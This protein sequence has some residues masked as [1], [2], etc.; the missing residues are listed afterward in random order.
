MRYLHLNS[1]VFCLCLLLLAANISGIPQALAAPVAQLQPILRQSSQRIALG[2]MLFF[3]RRLSGDGTMSCAVCHIP[4]QA[5]GD[6]RDISGAYPTNKHWRNTQ[7]LLNAAYLQSFFWDGRSDSLVHQAR[8]PIESPFEMNSNLAFI[9]A[10]LAEIPEYQAAFRDSFGAEITPELI[11]A[12]L[13][14]FEQTLTVSDSPFDRYLAGEKSA[15]DA[16]AREGLK[17]FFG[18]R[19]GCSQCHAGP[20]L[21][22]QKFYNLGVADSDTLLKDPQHRSTRRYMLADQGLPMQDSDPGRYRLT[23]IRAEMG[24][25]RTPPLRQV[26][27]TG[28]YMHNGRF[29]TLAEVI[30]F[31][32]QGGGEGPG[33]SPLLSRRNFNA[34]EQAA[35]VAFLESLSGT[36][37]EIHRPRLPG[38]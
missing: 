1:T 20:L 10:K 19:G 24:A 2:Q 26:A 23:K 9:S 38:D 28:P 6:G 34:T 11:L 14:A 30:S 16:Q 35:L 12:A 25:F 4:D 31:L 29:K 5:F 8:G 36:V 21:S 7:T 32:S 18:S 27:Q 37:P 17:I 3:D 22:D 15:L 13:A 33:K